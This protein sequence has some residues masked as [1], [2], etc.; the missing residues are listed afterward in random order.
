MTKA[1]AA[2]NETLPRNDK[3]TIVISKKGKGPISLAKLKPLPEP[4]NIAQLT[5]A[6]MQHW[7]MTN[8]LDVLKETELRVHFTDAFR[9]LGSREDY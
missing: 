7:P 9:T 2:L 1:L 6:L 3:V 8:L 5:A 4:T